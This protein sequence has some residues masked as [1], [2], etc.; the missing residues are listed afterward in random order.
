M[1]YLPRKELEPDGDSLALQIDFPHGSAHSRTVWGTATPAA[2]NTVWHTPRRSVRRYSLL[3][4][5]STS[6][7]WSA[8]RS[9]LISAHSSLAPFFSSRVSSSFRRTRARKLQNTCPRIVSSTL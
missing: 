9:L 4:F 6:T 8:R 3:P 5:I 7:S 1:K 2:C